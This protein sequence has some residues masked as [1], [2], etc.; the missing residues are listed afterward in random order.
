VADPKGFM[1][2]AREGP[3]RR[4]VEL[5]LMDWK[6]FYEPIS[7]DKLKAQGARCMDCGVP[8]CQSHNGCPV[9]N[10]IPEWND[11]VHRGRW[12]DALKAL[13]TTNN[14]PEFTG[15]LCPAPCESA[16]VLAIN[17]D[18]VSIRIIEWNIID[19]GFDEGW[20]Q[21]ILPVSHTGKAVAVVGSGPAG[22][23]AAQQLARAGHSVTVFEKADRIGGLLRYG[24]P[25][26]KMEKWVIDRRLE[27]MQAEGV[28]FK[29]G[30]HVG[31]DID[32][33]TLRR[34]YDAICL[35][36]GAEQARELPVP[37]R[38]LKGIHLAMEYLTQQNKR[39]AGDSILE[40]PITAKGKRVVI[41]G[42]GDTG[43]DCLGTTHRQGCTEVHQFE[44]LPEPPPQ[45][46][47][48]TPWP[49]WPMQLRSSHAHEEGCDR[50]W[51]V[52][53][54][55]FTGHNGQVTKLHAARVSFENGK[56]TP[57]PNSEVEMEA[58]LVL[59]AM[60]FTGPV[61]HGLLDSLGVQ[62]DARGNAAVDENCMTNVPGVFA[63]GDVK[64]GASLIVWAIAEGR[65]MAAGV[66]TYLHARH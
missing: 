40:E 22:L 10:L 14:F 52:S 34:Q 17:E 13:H 11:M 3:K 60:G 6:E 49:L 58:D 16:C 36:M 55:R 32:A 42:G 31:V 2:Y 26:F 65:K 25:E 56:F 48:S 38:E 1:K 37:G 61:K 44:L 66:E 24:I 23:T 57:V 50:Q 35:A 7:E 41:L 39:N 46:A 19:R 4:P 45:R 9:V 27:Q 47:E 64:R 30:V 51:N 59:L 18:P 43:S 54:T 20:V 62:Y 28:Q 15:R 29:T 5:R 63:G 12:E 21:P 33:E 53:T 8:F